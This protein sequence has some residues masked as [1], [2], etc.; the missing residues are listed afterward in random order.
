MH[1]KPVILRFVV[2]VTLAFAA[3]R[4]FGAS[5]DCGKAH[6]RIE[7]LIC[8]DAE[9]S[10][11]DEA[12]GKVYRRKL[13]QSADKATFTTE[14]KRWLRETRDACKDRE[15]LR[16]AYRARVT[17][18]KTSGDMASQTESAKLKHVS[19]LVARHVLNP[20]GGRNEAWCP[21]FLAE[22]RRADPKIE[23]IEP[24]FKTEDSNDPR[25]RHY[26]TCASGGERREYLE[27]K[28]DDDS[29]ANFWGVQD[30]GHRTF[31]LYKLPDP[32]KRGT[33]EVVYAELNWKKAMSNQFPGYGVVDLDKCSFERH[34][35]VDQSLQYEGQTRENFNAL[36]RY[37]ANYY[38]LNLS[39]QK[40]VSQ[41][42]T[43][44]SLEV[45][46]IYEKKPVSCWWKR[47]K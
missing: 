10:Q 32:A 28:L 40:G 6:S 9:L 15:C 34:V 41:T 45:K 39:D 8:Q 7:T 29:Q 33:V 35:I 31:R 26:Q 27:K 44:Y 11:L 18:M 47:S 46:P 36:I 14:Q 20:S 24:V 38:V 22:L 21:E 23:A 42:G 5:F 43:S 2:A 37:R 19:A 16:T 12:L 17:E 1:K 4:S 3:A 30:L 13:E 25:L